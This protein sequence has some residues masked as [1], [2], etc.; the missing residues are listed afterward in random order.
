MKNI[1]TPHMAPH[2][3]YDIKG[4]WRNRHT[5]HHIE[6]G[7]LMKDEDLH[8][9]ILLTHRESQ[10]AWEQLNADTRFL[11]NLGIMVGAHVLQ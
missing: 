5:N 10:R 8:K 6:E 3:K 7:R 9:N 4:S 1:F 11:T 2:E